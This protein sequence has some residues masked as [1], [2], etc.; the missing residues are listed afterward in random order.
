MLSNLLCRLFVRGYE[1]PEEPKARLGYG[2]LTGFVGVTVNLL[3]FVVKLAAGLFAGSIAIASDAVN[4]L[5]DAGTSVIT[6]VGFKLSA[7]PADNGHPFGHGRSEYIAGVIVSVIIL[8]VGFDFLKE[9]VMRIFSPAPVHAGWGVFAVIGGTL[10]FKGWLFFFY[11]KIG[12]KI[13]SEVIRAAAV[14]SL[15]DILGT[16]VVLGAVFAA[17]FTAFPVDAC[18][19]AVVALMILFAGFRV[20]KETT[21]PLLGECPDPE[22][23]Q[24]LRELLLSCEGI[25]GVH[26]IILHNY[27]PNQYF[28]TAHA[29]VSLDGTP[30]S[31]HDM[32][33]AAEVEVGKKLPIHLLLHCDP[34]DTTDPVVKEWR[35]K[36]E[37]VVAEFDSKF[38]VYDFR[39]DE[40]GPVRSLC[41]HLLFPRNYSMR[42]EDVTAELTLR[43]R[44]YDPALQLKIEFVHSYV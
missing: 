5:S 42:Q 12:K 31:I 20:L 14:D 38:K 24:K 18:A 11:R 37:E 29:E 33:E 26:D 4:N 2:L 39:L 22:L 44:K 15:S 1:N 16:L 36:L 32:L 35:V 40:S 28:A 8:A 21:D 19:G 9:S 34:Y 17:R 27:G 13:D 10:L 25:R 23:V 30:L 41:F 6:I 3:L 43:M 7:V